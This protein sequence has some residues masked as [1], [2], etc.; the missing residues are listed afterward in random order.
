MIYLFEAYNV[1]PCT[2]T[3]Y[4]VCCS[5]CDRIATIIRP[6]SSSSTRG[7]LRLPTLL[8][9]GA[10]S[11]RFY[12][13]FIL[14]SKLRKSNLRGIRTPAP[15]LK[16]IRGYHK[17]TGATGYAPPVI[18]E[19]QCGLYLKSLQEL[20]VPPRSDGG[21]PRVQRLRAH[22]EPHLLGR[23]SRKTNPRVHGRIPMGGLS[24]SHHEQKS[25]KTQKK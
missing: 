23:R 21:D 18:I 10:L 17:T 7:E 22:L 16:N 14:A 8:L 19:K 4:E 5:P 13:L 3:P 25:P 9:I 24:G 12:L 1:M 15:T 2:P 20:R 11:S 6:V